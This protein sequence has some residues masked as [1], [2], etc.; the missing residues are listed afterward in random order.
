M[1]VGMTGGQPAAP[2]L[3]S[4]VRPNPG[5]N[6]TW[7]QARHGGLREGSGSPGGFVHHWQ[8]GGAS[9]LGEEGSSATRDSLEDPD[10]GG[11]VLARMECVPRHI[12]F[13]HLFRG[14]RE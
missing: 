7:L 8:C 4:C 5:R 10:T 1:Y 9:E 3:A 6:F 13:R 14:A 11:E 2:Q 12:A